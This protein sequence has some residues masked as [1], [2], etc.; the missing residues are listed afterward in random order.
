MTHEMTEAMI[1][2]AGIGGVVVSILVILA[3]AALTKYVFFR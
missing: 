2:G 1:W 3:I